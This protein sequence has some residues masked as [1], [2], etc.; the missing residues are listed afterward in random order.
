MAHAYYKLNEQRSVDTNSPNTSPPLNA[1]ADKDAP[2]S[3]LQNFGKLMKPYFKH[4]MK[5]CFFHFTLTISLK[6]KKLSLISHNDCMTMIANYFML[7]VG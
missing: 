5:R 4:S 2:N 3:Y 6:I 7:N 1:K